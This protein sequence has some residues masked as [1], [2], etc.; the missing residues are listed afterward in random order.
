MKKILRK[1]PT[2]GGGIDK[3]L[4]RGYEIEIWM[5]D[6]EFVIETNESL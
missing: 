3:I 4:D 6:G 5:M 2:E 1:I